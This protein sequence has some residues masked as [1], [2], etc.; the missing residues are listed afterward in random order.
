MP[1]AD[2]A[3]TTSRRTLLASAALV[4]PVALLPA[5]AA[6]LPAVPMVPV[7]DDPHPAWHRAWQACL[8]HMNGPA[9]E[10]VDDLAELPEW[11]RALELEEMIGT[12]RARTA[13]GVLA[14]L[15]VLAHWNGDS[16][17]MPDREVAAIENAL[18]TLERLSGEADHD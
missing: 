8:D 14:Q 17:C 3:R 15:R 13:A 1:K 2:N 10:T 18:A 16:S 4:A 5:I 12:T 7:G 9:G 6:G 11:H